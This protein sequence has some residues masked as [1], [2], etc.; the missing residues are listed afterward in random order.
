VLGRPNQFARTA[1]DV[2]KIGYVL[3]ETWY[4][5]KIEAGRSC[6]FGMFPLAS[7]SST[8]ERVGGIA[9]PLLC[10]RAISVLPARVTTPV[11]NDT[12]PDRHSRTGR[13]RRKGREE[14]QPATGSRLDGKKRFSRRRG[15]GGEAY[16]ETAD[17][18]AFRRFDLRNE[19]ADTEAMLEPQ[20]PSF[21]R[22]AARKERSP[23]HEFRPVRCFGGRHRR[24]L[25]IPPIAFGR[26]NCAK[27]SLG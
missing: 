9:L 8:S 23:G 27:Q 7:I 10:R 12:P 21:W 15:P 24:E 17:A 1:K 11:P 25:A 13:L 19:F 14:R 5:G 3:I 4:A 18:T 20:K 16:S 2:Q 22:A 26:C 6:R